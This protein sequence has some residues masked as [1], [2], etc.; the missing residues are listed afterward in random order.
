M[1][2]CAYP[3]DPQIVGERWRAMWRERLDHLVPFPALWLQHQW[4][5]GFW[6]HGSVCEDYGAI[7]CACTPSAAGRTATPT[8][9]RG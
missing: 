5:D 4:R 6:K 1:T 8:P 9:C 7:R 2:Y 3:P